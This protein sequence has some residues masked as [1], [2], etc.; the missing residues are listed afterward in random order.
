M[1]A[2]DKKAAAYKSFAAVWNNVRDYSNDE[3][4]VRHFGITKKTIYARA[5]NL[6]RF[7]LA[8]TDLA[9]PE[10]ISRKEVAGGILPVPD[11]VIEQMEEYRICDDIYKDAK[12]IIVTSAQFGASL[13]LKFWQSL[14]NYSDVVGFPIVVLPIKYGAVKVSK[15]GS[16]LGRFAKK[17]KGHIQLD[18]RSVACGTLTLN[19][20]R[21]R[22][23]LSRFLS[24][25]ICELGGNSSQIM[26]APKMELEHRPR[27]SHKYPKAIMTTGAVTVPNYQVDNLGQQDRTGE[28]A[29]QE[30]TYGA[31]VV[32][33]A[34][35][36]FHFRQLLASKSGVFY[37]IDH[38]DGGAMLVTPEGVEH[39]PDDVE[40]LVLGD[41]HAGKTCPQ[42]RD[43]T[44]GEGGLIPTLKPASIVL[45]D[46]VD[47]D[48]I[49]WHDKFH[50]VRR[51]VKSSR[52]WGSLKNELDAA[53]E[54]T[55]YILQRFSGQVYV[56]ASNH[57]EFI[58]K[59]IESLDWARDD[60]NIVTGARLFLAMYDYMQENT[61]DLVDTKELDPVAHYIRQHIQ[62][63]RVVF[64]E[65]Q[66]TL[67]I[68]S[69]GKSKILCSL[70]G[71]IGTKGQ[72]SRSTNDFRK[73]NSRIFLGHNH[74][75]QI[76]GPVWRVGVSTPLTQHYVQSPATNWT[77]THGVIFK[78]G[79]RQ[80]IN[81][82]NGDWHGQE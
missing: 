31:I 5:A 19:T 4:L 61:T 65:R 20:V 53:V 75:A 49:S 39:R 23:T 71:D 56:T 81:I 44:F 27:L 41:W 50:A 55:E 25:P 60:E 82:I 72:R 6:K 58:T 32:E 30:H 77:N 36:Q 66:D 40:A 11:S 63:E 74:S 48:S 13:N 73:M 69:T 7:R 33:M 51:A 2:L 67:L 26:A 28:I 59:Y 43:A 52:G 38:Y 70:H 54:E 15:D 64:V 76:W 80:L 37:D 22:P 45:H 1:Q 79:Q 16:L 12:G 10:L 8:N 24:D 14:K 9:L 18:N 35:D 47:G 68:P 21:M 34:G 29:L 42:V 3:S 46:Y 78:N 57:P 17:L 62:S